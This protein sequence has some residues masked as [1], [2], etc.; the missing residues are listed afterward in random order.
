MTNSISKA[1][2]N[3]ADPVVKK[4]NQNVLIPKNPLIKDVHKSA[5]DFTQYATKEEIFTN[6]WQMIKPENYD[7]DLVD[8]TQAEIDFSVQAKK[9]DIKIVDEDERRILVEAKD[10]V[11]SKG[12][13]LKKKK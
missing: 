13:T 4:I 7:F 11:I 1:H 6:G 10:K 9:D 5:G 2:R 3:L 12:I 8:V